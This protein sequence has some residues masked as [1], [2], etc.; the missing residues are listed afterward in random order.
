MK[1]LTVEQIYLYLEKELAPAE[2]K[3]IED[4]IA[5]CPK[6]KNALE[7]RRL[8]LKAA[9]TLPLWQT[10]SDFTQR[11]MAKIFPSRASVAAWLGAA[12]AGFA[13]VILTLLLFFLVSGQ[14][15]SS[16]LLSFNHSLWNYV[17][18]L[19]PVFV[20]LLKLA[21]VTY[22]IIQQLAGHLLKIFTWLTTIVSPELQIII[23]AIVI[24]LIISF[25][26]GIKRKIFIGERA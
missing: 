17:R 12:A 21:A 26:Y 9:E 3:K 19:L 7:E 14:N 11:V 1:C 16:L 22:K 23:T 18:N 10:P 8:L 4:H 24:V 20:K 15:L 6:C 5:S 2:N 25:I 13:S